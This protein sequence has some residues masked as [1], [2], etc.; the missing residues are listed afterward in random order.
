MICV[1]ETADA[2]TPVGAVGVLVSANTLLVTKD[3]VSKRVIPRIIFL[4]FNNM[5]ENTDVF[6]HYY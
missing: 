5:Y 4:L 1:G 6:R 3:R 2:D